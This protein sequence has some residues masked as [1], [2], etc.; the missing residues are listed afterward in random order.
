MIAGMYKQ[1][2]KIKSSEC[3][4]TLKKIELTYALMNTGG[5]EKNHPIK[6]QQQNE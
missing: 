6:Q 4:P 2:K 5:R 3:Q 1:N